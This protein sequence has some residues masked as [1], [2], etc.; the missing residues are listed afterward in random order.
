MARRIRSIFAVVALAL[1]ALSAAYID[2]H[3]LSW[4]A[5]HFCYLGLAS[6][7][8]SAINML[9]MNRYEKRRNG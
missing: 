4:Q 6:M 1:A 9:L 5:N 2:Y 7:I 8:G 3:D